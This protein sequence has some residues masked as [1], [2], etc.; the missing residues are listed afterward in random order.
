M[1]TVSL[2]E[3]REDAKRSKLK[4]GDRVVFLPMGGIWGGLQWM[5]GVIIKKNKDPMWRFDVEIDLPHL[6][7]PD[8]SHMRKND[9]ITCVGPTALVKVEQIRKEDVP[10]LNNG[11]GPDGII[12]KMSKLVAL[13]LLWKK[14][15]EMDEKELK[16]QKEAQQKGWTDSWWKSGVSRAQKRIDHTQKMITEFTTKIDKLREAGIVEPPEYAAPNSN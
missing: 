4:V 14:I 8:T 1:T 16:S 5:T 9:F 11:L 13:R 12:P 2:K 15:L 6:L 3:I 7:Y 10:K